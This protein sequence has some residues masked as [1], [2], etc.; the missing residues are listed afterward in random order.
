MPRVIVTG[1]A[2]FIGS[3]LSEA[4]IDSG[5]EVVGVDCFTPFYARADK[6]ANLGRLRQEPR[7]ELREI[8]LAEETEGG[9]AGM[10]EG[11]QAVF[12]QAAQAGVR[13]SWAAGFAD[14]AR[15]NVLGTQRL[16]E[17]TRIA[18]GVGRVV[19]A[20]SS[21][22]Y[23]DAEHHPTTEDALPRPHSPYGVT[24]LAAE[25]LAG[26]YARNFGLPTISLRYFTVYGP[27]QRPDMAFRRFCSA[28][29]AR[30]PIVVHGDGTQARDFTYVDDIVSANLAA[31]EAAVAPG[32][33]CNIGGGAVTSVRDA[34]DLLAGMVGRPLD[35]RFEEPAAGDA[36]RTSADLTRAA[37]LLGWH[38]VTTLSTGLAAELAWVAERR[39]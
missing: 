1:A 22:I 12:H 6:E 34:L 21:S 18:G 23:G 39:P 10:V 11:A 4:L 2:G 26:L 38:P 30:A 25:H 35:V 32:E 31:A 3:H 13:T 36:R 7:F 8:D 37:R 15:W 16:L 14:Y 9:L 20:S 27:R 19:V 33:V 29:L 24:K 5:H 28:A 17:A